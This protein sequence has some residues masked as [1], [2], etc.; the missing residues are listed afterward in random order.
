[1]LQ[2]SCDEP[3]I[4]KEIHLVQKPVKITA[5]KYGI[6]KTTLQERAPFYGIL[7]EKTWMIL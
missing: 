6:P 5:N 3:A 1:M 2:C 4:E 7:L